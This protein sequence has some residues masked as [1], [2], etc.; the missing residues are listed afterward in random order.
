MEKP[1]NSRVAALRAKFQGNAGGYV[2]TPEHQL[3][4][5]S[6]A[7]KDQQRAVRVAKAR[8][9][10]YNMTLRALAIKSNVQVSKMQKKDREK[11]LSTM[12][13]AAKYNMTS[14]ALPVSTVVSKRDKLN[15]GKALSSN[16]SPTVAKEVLNVVA[17]KR[18]KEDV[19]ETKEVIR[20]TVL[21]RDKRQPSKNYLAAAKDL[22]KK[23]AEEAA[24]GQEQE[25]IAEVEQK[26]SSEGTAK[27]RI[28]MG[29]MTEALASGDE[30][31]I[32][33]VI[34][35]NFL[36]SN[37]PHLVEKVDSLVEK[38]KDKMQILFDGL[39][40][41]LPD[42]EDAKL[43]GRNK[44]DKEIVEAVKPIEDIEKAVDKKVEESSEDSIAF[45]PVDEDPK[46]KPPK[47]KTLVEEAFGSIGPDDDSLI[48]DQDKAY[49]DGYESVILAA[50]EEPNTKIQEIVERRETVLRADN[51]L[52]KELDTTYKVEKEELY[53]EEVEPFEQIEK[54]ESVASF[55]SEDSI[56]EVPDVEAGYIVSAEFDEAA[57][58]EEPSR[59]A[60][61]LQ[62]KNQALRDKLTKQGL[63]VEQV[64]ELVN[65]FEQNTSEMM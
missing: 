9:A 50:E 28:E 18:N 39:L 1:S 58:E 31:A 2:P 40:Q 43:N 42:A 7:K 56:I 25:Q 14:R 36:Q 55:V 11:K 52:Q 38:Y 19:E 34:L 3:G 12:R 32:N 48:V 57:T 54:A 17:K 46:P 23:K 47:K 49:H 44:A 10:R 24:A 33:K 8:A 26:D 63:T 13:D 61:Q 20:T 15:L 45:V 60:V 65:N 41:E 29:G 53:K 37:A 5:M 22:K 27:H 6:K 64:D 35:T 21:K 4:K 59:W 16:V 30:D 51:D 62:N